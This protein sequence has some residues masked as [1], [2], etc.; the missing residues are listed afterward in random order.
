MTRGAYLIVAAVAALILLG[1]GGAV[2]YGKTRG[3]RNNNPGN[4]RKGAQWQGMADIQPDN[5]FIT[6]KTPAYGLRAMGRVLYVYRT[7]H[8]LNT[9][10]GIINR[11]APP[12]E[13]DTEAYVQHAARIVGI[14]P[15]APIDD[16]HMP[17]LIAA[18]V[19]HENGVQPYPLKLIEYGLSIA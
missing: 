14:S 13:N 16:E 17:L 11:W 10:R 6:F 9:I 8:G 4:I 1:G 19:K 7:R 3:L 15:D 5:E 2:I 18:I 12:I